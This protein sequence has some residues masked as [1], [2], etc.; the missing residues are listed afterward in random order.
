MQFAFF[1]K[2]DGDS[3]VVTRR[4]L[5]ACTRRVWRGNPN[6]SGH[7]LSEART[8]PASPGAWYDGQ[9]AE[10]GDKCAWTFGA[11]LVTFSNG[12]QWKI[13]GWRER[14]LHGRHWISKQ[15]GPKR[16]VSVVNEPPLESRFGVT[17][18]RKS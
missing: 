3:V 5:Q 18:K 8:D 17:S 2:L 15:L 9:G 16:A 6:V 14:C 1:F 12:S 11:P 7:E 13:Q 4:I 10:N